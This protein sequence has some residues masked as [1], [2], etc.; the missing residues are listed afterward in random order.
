MEPDPLGK[1]QKSNHDYQLVFFREIFILWPDNL[2]WIKKKMALLGDWVR[3]WIYLPKPSVL[4]ESDH[5]LKNMPF[6]E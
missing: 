3:A 2:K 4:L 6:K 1:K 5:D